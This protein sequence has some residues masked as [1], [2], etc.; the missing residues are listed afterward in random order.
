MIDSEG[1][2]FQP[3]AYRHQELINVVCSTDPEMDAYM[4][5][6]SYVT[7]S[8]G[9]PSCVGLDVCE[10]NNGLILQTKILKGATNSELGGFNFV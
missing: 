2:T 3:L 1:C 10:S 5:V 7:R 6:V 9:T 4:R 8:L